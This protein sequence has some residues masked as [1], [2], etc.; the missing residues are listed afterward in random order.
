MMWLLTR[1]IVWPVKTAGYGLS[2]G[3]RT[4]RLVGYRRLTVFGL[5][6][7]VGM[8]LA[9]GPGA[10]L[11]AV[12]KERLFPASDP[13]ALPPAPQARHDEPIDLTATGI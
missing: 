6:V 7:V 13:I 11:R 1:P 3:Y 10:E 4:G 12:L 9:P 5:G 8:L 2:A